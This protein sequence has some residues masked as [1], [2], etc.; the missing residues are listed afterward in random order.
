MIRHS[1]SL[2]SVITAQQEISYYAIDLLVTSQS[3]IIAECFRL[4]SLRKSSM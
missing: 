2:S 1:P 4:Y 3:D